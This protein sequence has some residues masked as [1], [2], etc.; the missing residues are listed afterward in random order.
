M[1]ISDTHQAVLISNVNTASRSICE[2]LAT[3][4]GFEEKTPKHSYRLTEVRDKFGDEYALQVAGYAVIMTT[5][6]PFDR[7]VS[8]WARLVES[9]SRVNGRGTYWETFPEF[10]SF[11]ETFLQLPAATFEGYTTPIGARW[12]SEFQQVL[13]LPYSQQLVQAWAD[14]DFGGVDHFLDFSNSESIGALPFVTPPVTLSHIGASGVSSSDY[15][16]TENRRLVSLWDLGV[17]R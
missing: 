14:E 12:S 13:T 11:I 15:D 6:D 10:A 8:I 9:D 1:Y 4:Y 5:R 17:T 16:T 3:N 2:F 7:A